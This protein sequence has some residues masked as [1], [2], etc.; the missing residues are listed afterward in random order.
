MNKQSNNNPRLPIRFKRFTGKSYAVYNSLN[1]VITIGVVTGAVLAAMIVN[2][3]KGQTLGAVESEEKEREHRL[4]EVTVTAARLDASIYHPA[5]PATVIAAKDIQAA[6]ARSIQDLLVN[7][8]GVDIVQRGANGVQADI[9]LRG[10]SFDQNAVMLNGVNLSS[11]HT[12]HY[13]LD[14]PINLADIERIEIV[15]GPAALQCGPGAFSGGINIIT[16][17]NETPKIHAAI[18]AGMHRLRG[19]QM[20]IAR[21]AGPTSHSISAGH[22]SSAGYMANTDYNIFNA[23]WQ[24]QLRSPGAKVDLQLGYNDKQYGAN[25]FYS[26][27]FP[28]QYEQTSSLL[29]SIRAE[30]GR[31]QSFKLIPTAAWNRHYDRFELTKGSDAGRNHHRNDSY[32]LSLAAAITSPLGSTAAGAAMQRDDILSSVLGRP[33]Q[34]PQGDYRMSDSRTNSSL[35]AEH[36]LAFKQFTASAGILAYHTTVSGGAPAA[37]YPSAAAAWSP[38]TR[39]RASASWSRSTRLPT[40]TDLYYTT[41]THSGDAGLRPEQ[42][43]AFEAGLRYAEHAVTAH[44]SGFVLHGKNM[45][46]WVKTEASAGKWAS[47]NHTSIT[48]RGIEASVSMRINSEVSVNAGYTRMNQASESLGMTSAYS[49]NYLRD[50]ITVRVTHPIGRRIASASWHIRYQ[51]RM[52]TY[53]KYENLVKTADEPFPPFATVDLAISR[54]MGPLAL[55][56]HFRNLLNQTY[57]DKGNIPQPG[58]W[59]MG[60][61]TVDVNL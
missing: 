17:K 54:S 59:I 45:I 18:E 20:R 37:F 58:L 60:R 8:A 16:R 33:L 30:L 9:S 22:N 55:H 43:E 28:S 44:I 14:I 15:S 56:L 7:H 32:S 1:K 61:A 35:F 34:K 31:S 24:S 26:P 13:A 29:G 46:D 12:G 39:W 25:S 52:G 10:G 38:S 51:K 21:Q 41:E 48:T 5:R 6:P 42:S 2:P 19:Y 50:K 3:A 36:S 27:R 40:F 23:L 11:A 49:L 47:W 4:A 53:E 57:F